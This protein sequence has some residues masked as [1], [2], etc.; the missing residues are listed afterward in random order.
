MNLLLSREGVQQECT[1]VRTGA[2]AQLV[3]TD[4]INEQVGYIS[5]V[6]FT[7]DCAQD[8]AKALESRCV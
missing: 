2:R 5:I 7:D 8:F 6:E 3:F 4:T 1:L